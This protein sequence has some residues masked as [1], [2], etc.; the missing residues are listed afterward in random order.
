VIV[1]NPPRFITSHRPLRAA[2]LVRAAIDP[3]VAIATLLACVVS[4]DGGLDGPALILTLLVFALTFPGSRDWSHANARALVRDIVA[5]WLVVIGLLLLLGWAS[6]TLDAFDRHSIAAWALATPALL[7]AA[8]RVAPGVLARVLAAEDRQRVAVIVGANELGRGLAA[9]IAA[10]P[11]L[12]IR[13]AGYFDDRGAQRLGDTGARR[14]L[15]PLRN[16]A[17]YVKSGRIDI[18]YIAL[19]MCS[20]PRVRM[21]LDELHDTTASIYFV[22]DILLFDLIQARVDTIGG[23]PLL[24]VCESPYAGIN[25]LIKRTSDLVL[26]SAILVLTA[27]LAAAIALG[28]KLSSPGSVLFRQRRYGVDGR[29]IVVY[30]FR[31]MTCLEDGDV[32]RQVTRDDPRTTRF[33]AFL[34]RY[35]LDELPQLVNVIQGR[36]SV[37]GPRPHAV[38]HNELYRKLIR[39]YMIRH[40]VRPGITGLAQVRGLRGETESIEK[41]C[42]RV[43]CDLEYLRHWSL[44]LDLR[45]VLRTIVVVLKRDNAY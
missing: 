37:V 35:S 30:K 7:F 13:V 19:P 26:A 16:L 3:V 27:P 42:A 24:A 15:G 14:V 4:L 25:A 17:D 21:L 20:H 29:E 40:K 18:I 41:M 43:E 34:R 44:L 2:A 38:A 11:L 33:G 32:V 1:A 8:H 45:I 22:P 12:G 9:R 10:N 6:Q 31:T 5:N 36:M 23:M 39:G 28:V